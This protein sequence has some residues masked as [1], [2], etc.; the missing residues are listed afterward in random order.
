MLHPTRY[1]PPV[2]SQPLHPARD[3]PTVRWE[4]KADSWGAKGSWELRPPPQEYHTAGVVNKP[5]GSNEGKSKHKG[6]KGGGSGKKGAKASSGEPK[7]KPSYFELGTTRRGLD[8]AMWEVGYIRPDSLAQGWIRVAGRRHAV[9]Y[10][11]NWSPSRRHICGK[12]VAITPS[13]MR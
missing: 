10:A 4:A 2:T 7:E 12:L 8:G 13:H 6:A 11:A 1:I 3:I 9:T 5:A